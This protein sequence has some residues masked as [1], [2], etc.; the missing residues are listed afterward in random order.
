MMG[1]LG[2][3]GAAVCHRGGGTGPKSLI[4]RPAQVAVAGCVRSDSWGAWPARAATLRCFGDQSLSRVHV[5]ASSPTGRQLGGERQSRSQSMRLRCP[6]NCPGNCP[7][8]KFVSRSG[9]ELCPGMAVEPFS[10]VAEGYFAGDR[11]MGW[12][13][14]PSRAQRI[15][16][17]DLEGQMRMIC[18]AVGESASFLSPVPTTRA[19][20]RGGPWSQRHSKMQ[21]RG[22]RIREVA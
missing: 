4:A 16:I 15:E 8:M 18:G 22:L 12:L 14:L 6:G 2:G 9:H 11:S 10:R 20:H 1:G 13:E 21:C 7:G 5:V 19:C 17:L 3:P